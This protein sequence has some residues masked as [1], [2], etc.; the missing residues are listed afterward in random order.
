MLIPTPIAGERLR[1]LDAL[2]GIAALMVVIHHCSLMRT[3]YYEVS[4]MAS[5][6]GSERGLSFLAYHAAHWGRAA[7]LLFFMLSGFV[8][9]LSL[10]GKKTP[11]AAYAVKRFFRIYPV[12]AFSIMASLLLF[13]F[14][15]PPV[16]DFHS[17][18]LDKL[19][20]AQIS[21]KIVL[22][23]LLMLGT[24]ESVGLSLV[25]WSLVYE[26]RVSLVFPLLRAFITRWRGW[27]LALCATVSIVAG[28]GVLGDGRGE[29]LGYNDLDQWAVLLVTVYFGNF[30]AMGILLA[31]RREGVVRFWQRVPGVMRAMVYVVAL[32]CIFATCDMNLYSDVRMKIVFDY[33]NA[34]GAALLI[35]LAIADAR[36]AAVLMRRPFLWLGRVS[37]SLYM[38]HLLVIYVVFRVLWERCSVLE[39]SVVVIMASL[40]AAEGVSRFVEYPMMGLGRRLAKVRR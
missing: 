7:V 19:F 18:W 28:L 1:P 36:F 6:E 38:V 8:L 14:L 30:F 34:A 33:V 12:F 39:M 35:M 3:D 31:A 27:G 37:Y 26:L 2:R 20:G 25:M 10:E 23:H 16:G 22:G 4:L 32:C 5:L 29:N 11:Y 21:A 13:Y 24:P 17:W 40:L 9:T 15:P